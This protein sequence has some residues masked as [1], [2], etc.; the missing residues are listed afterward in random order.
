M[1]KLN[2]DKMVK[3]YYSVRHVLSYNRP[4]NAITGP[5][6]TTKSTSVALWVICYWYQTEQGWIYT[7]RDKDTT[8]GTAEDFIV[9]AVAIIN[10]FYPDLQ[11]NIEYK[12]GKPGKYYL[13]DKYRD[14]PVLCGFAV[15]L[16]L[17]AKYKGKNFSM[18]DWVVFDEF[19]KSAD[20]HYGGG[21]KDITRE[22]VNLHQLMQTADRGIGVLHRNKVR[23]ICMGNNDSYFNP[24]YIAK[25]IDKYLRTETKFLAPKSEAYVVQQ[26]SYADCPNAEGYEDTMLYKLADD[27][28]KDYAYRNINKEASENEF[29]EDHDKDSLKPVCE[30]TFDNFHMV[31]YQYSDGLYIAPGTAPGRKRFALT[32]EDHTPDYNLPNSFNGYELIQIR[33][34]YDRGKVRF[35]NHKCKYCL[36]NYFKYIV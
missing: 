32:L 26:L 31:C 9:N 1:L 35:K 4:L 12:G 24:I 16:N 13:T 8:D 30:M 25:G 20:E 15:P 6:G 29:I 7:R 11:L 5:R 23:A 14:E 33:R 21:S 17:Q 34:L 36:D 18:C 2:Y 27:R 3:G 19:I 22:F 28:T 10:M